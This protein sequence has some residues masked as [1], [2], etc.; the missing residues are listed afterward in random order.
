MTKNKI[1]KQHLEKY[2]AITQKAIDAVEK[3]GFDND[4][5][6]MALD[7]F[8]MAKRYYSDAKHYYEKG[9]WV[10]AFAAINY[11]HGWLDAGARSELFKVKDSTLFTVDDD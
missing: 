6:I 8:D 10:T 3:G 5:K 4:R 1:S 7:F 11:S 2:F 9:E